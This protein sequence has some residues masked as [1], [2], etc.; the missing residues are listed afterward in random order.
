MGREAITNAQRIQPEQLNANLERGKIYVLPFLR[1]QYAM[2]IEKIGIMPQGTKN[3]IPGDIR[4]DH[5]GVLTVSHTE[6]RARILLVE[7]RSP[8]DYLQAGERITWDERRA[9]AVP[10]KQGQSC[11]E[12]CAD[13]DKMVCDGS[14]LHF[15]NNCHALE[16]H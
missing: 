9:K 2:L 1:E 5:Y 13:Q 7:K 16:K 10:G 8:R 11:F 3:A 15:V 14:Q 6:S 12:V 4:T